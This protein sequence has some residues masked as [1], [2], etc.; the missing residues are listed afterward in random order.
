MEVHGDKFEG[1]VVLPSWLD[2]QDTD[3]LCVKTE[4]YGVAEAMLKFK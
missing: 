3:Y 1:K 2:L 4:Q